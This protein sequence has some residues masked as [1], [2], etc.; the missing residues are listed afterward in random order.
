MK[1]LLVWS[2]FTSLVGCGPSDRQQY[3]AE[4]ESLQN[5]EQE[6]RDLDADLASFAERKNKGD[7]AFDSPDLDKFLADE[8]RQMQE[9]VVVQEK[10]VRDARNRLK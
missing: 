1:R 10:R 9:A 7:S 8:R 2:V 6:I 4:V 3:N 5:L